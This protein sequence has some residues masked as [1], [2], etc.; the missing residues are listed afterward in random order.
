MEA[1]KLIWNSWENG[2]KIEILPDKIMPYSRNEAYKIQKQI[3]IYSKNTILGWKIAAT[4]KDGQNHIGVSGPLAGRIFKEKVT[5]PNSVIALGHN[6]MRVAEPEF[7][8]KIGSLIKPN[9][10]LFILEEVMELVD[11]LYLA[12]E[13]PDSRFN[14]FSCVG[15]LN[16]I[17]DNAC[18]DQF[19][20]S[21]PIEK[22]WKKIDFSN[23]KLSISNSKF[24]YQGIGSNVLGDPRV[25]LTWLVNEL[26]QNNIVLEK[27]MIVSTGTCSKP[28]PVVTGDIVTANFGK[29]GEISVKLK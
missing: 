20:I 29:L 22:D 10:T 5:N 1:A 7:A 24:S 25:A 17:A 13:F 23:F 11:S 26:S 18:A 19:V 15:E 9:K 3:E 27:G 12:I 2:K 4:S 6:K 8:F 14:N 28:I 21:S 16:L